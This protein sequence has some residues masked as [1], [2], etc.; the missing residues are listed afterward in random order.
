M[1]IAEELIH[2]IQLTE[3]FSAY[4]QK[5]PLALAQKAIS[6]KNFINWFFIQEI[7]DSGHSDCWLPHKGTLPIEAELNSGTLTIKQA[8]EGYNIGRTVLIR[9]A[10]KAHPIYAALAKNFNQCF[11]KPIDIQLYCTP[12]NQEGFNWH[13]DVEDVF[14]IQT[15]GEKE[16]RLLENTVTPRPLNVKSDQAEY[17]K[18]ERGQEI[19]CWL[20]AGD[21]LYIPA[22]YWH[23]AKAL[24]DSFHISIGVM[25]Q[26]IDFENSILEEPE[27]PQQ[28][29]LEKRDLSTIPENQS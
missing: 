22:G 7:L 16:F 14:V 1:F 5:Q 4:F 28:K 18:K 26:H 25:Y 15:S 29:Y 10:E 17:F 23:K 13:Y 27:P 9:H 11:S 20:K 12:G 2:P 24:T 8:L 3:F 21:C 19:S 6:F